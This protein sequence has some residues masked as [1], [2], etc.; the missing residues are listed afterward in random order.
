MPINSKSQR[1]PKKGLVAYA[2]KEGG[3]G[4]KSGKMGREESRRPS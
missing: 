4:K 2:R 1:S 3:L